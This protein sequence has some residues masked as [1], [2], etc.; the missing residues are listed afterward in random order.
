MTPTRKSYVIALEITT[1]APLSHGAG[2]AGNEQVLRT[3]EMVVPVRDE[4]G[5]VVDHE[6]VAVPIVSGSALKATL[7]EHAVMDMFEVAGVEAGSVSLDGLRLLQKGGKNDSGGQTMALDKV[8][9]L[10]DLF[11]LITVFGAMDGGMPIAGAIQVSR[12]VPFCKAAVEAGA[13]PRTVRP[14][15]VVTGDTVAAMKEIPVFEGMTPLDDSL[16]RSTETYYRHDLRQGRTVK[17]IEGA[18]VRALEDKSAA[19]KELPARAAT[20]DVRRDANESMPHSMQVI[21]TGVPMFAEIRLN[22]VT[23]VEFACFARALSRWRASGAHLGGASSKGHGACRVR[24]AGAIVHEPSTAREAL[25]QTSLAPES[26][27]DAYNDQYLAHIRTR[28][29]AIRAKAAEVT[30]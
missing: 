30:R 7:R 21:A 26:I 12:V 16:V 22:D 23:E 29:D 20:K 10:R 28:A 13:V 11:P 15:Q 5:R 27:A 14:M 8:R 19:R 18:E 24:V 25:G 9:E 2:T 6:R 17:Y 1:T 4:S 3:S